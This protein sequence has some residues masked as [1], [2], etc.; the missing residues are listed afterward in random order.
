MN[1]QLIT[2]EVVV[3]GRAVKHYTHNGKTYIEAKTGTQYEL[4]VR[5]NT[6]AKILAVVSVDGLNVI[7]GE[8]AT[9]EDI[10]YLVEG[11]GSSL[12]RG[13]RY[14]NEEVGAFKFVSKD[15]SYSAQMSQDTSNIGV[16]GLIAFE[17]RDEK[18]RRKGKHSHRATQISAKG[19]QHVNS[20]GPEWT[21][22][23]N[24]MDTSQSVRRSAAG[25]SSVGGELYS[26]N[27]S[28][29]PHNGY[30]SNDA[31]LSGSISHEPEVKHS[32]GTG[33]GDRV[34]QACREVPFTKGVRIS[35][36]TLFYSSRQDLI[37]SGVIEL[38]PTVKIP[39]A[40]QETKYATPPPG[41]I[42]G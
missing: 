1:A 17:D 22:T 26:A 8:R 12:I 31:K 38:N 34:Q 37:E 14:S 23:M 33:W 2:I 10:G 19:G 3:N 7:N 16:I 24:F 35:E 4:K 21:G 6:D 27:S 30:G 41:Y 36:S 5:N 9:P 15:A 29:D 20:V 40:F 42:V 28:Y 11:R 13:F 25:G 18:L 39:S 32:V